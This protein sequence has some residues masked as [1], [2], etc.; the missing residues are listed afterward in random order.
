MRIII[1]AGKRLLR[2][3]ILNLKHLKLVV[4]K[5]YLVLPQNMVNMIKNEGK[6]FA[7]GDSNHSV[8]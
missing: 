7:R 8:H 5:I 3:T 1:S 4:S 6:N 2:K